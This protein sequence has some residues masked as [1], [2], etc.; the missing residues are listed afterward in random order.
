M[1]YS[2]W[3]CMTTANEYLTRMEWNAKTLVV[4]IGCLYEMPLAIAKKFGGG[5]RHKTGGVAANHRR[6][7]VDDEHG[8]THT[9]DIQIWQLLGLQLHL[10]AGG[11]PHRERQQ[12]EQQQTSSIH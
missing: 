6:F 3:F 5:C 7:S 9:G 2:Q 12:Q 11:S 8:V 1:A 10:A 4:R